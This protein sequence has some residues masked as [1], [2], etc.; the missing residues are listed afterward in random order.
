MTS[1]LFSWLFETQPEPV[2]QTLDKLDSDDE[3]QPKQTAV[4]VAEKHKE[5]PPHVAQE[6]LDTTFNP[7]KQHRCTLHASSEPSSS[8]LGTN[9]SPCIPEYTSNDTVVNF[10]GKTV[11]STS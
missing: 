2:P 10:N 5:I 11:P 6:I 1:F 7:K 9:K 8:E 4:P 3:F